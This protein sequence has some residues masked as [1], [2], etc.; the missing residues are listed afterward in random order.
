MQPDPPE[1]L[2][3]TELAL[4]SLRERIRSGA[5]RPGQRL[6]VEELTRELGMSPT[7]IR[8]A[9]RLLQADR[10]VDYRAHRG[11]VVT[12]VTSVEVA[13]IIRLRTILEPLAAE[14]G[15]PAF[16]ERKLGEMKRLHLRLAKAPAS[17]RAVEINAAWHWAIYEASGSVYLN[18]FIRRLWDAYPWRT[19]WVLPGRAELSLREH[20]AIM[21]AILERDASAAAE[22][23]RHH[24]QSSA[25]TLLL[26]LERQMSAAAWTDNVET[27][28]AETMS[29]SVTQSLAGP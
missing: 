26:D 29:S 2:T 17:K 1:H 23:M 14:L 16:T 18:D 3:K 25:E 5:A 28:N 9:L 24:I 20:S 7:P 10:L 13:E 19:M 12:S 11:I 8:E 27:G 15:V 21:E 6:R 22:G 4:R